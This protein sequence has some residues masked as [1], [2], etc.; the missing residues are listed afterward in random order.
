MIDKLSE[1]N[2][3]IKGSVWDKNKFVSKYA[4]K[5]FVSIKSLK[6]SKNI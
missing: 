6:K 5:I 3:G 1:G 2:G 4:K